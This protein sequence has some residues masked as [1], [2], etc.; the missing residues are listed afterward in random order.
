MGYQLWTSPITGYRR[1]GTRLSELRSLTEAGITA[2]TIV[3][4]LKSCPADA[5]ASKA[6]Q[7]LRRR[8]FD[9]AG[10]K[11]N[12]ES[13]VVTWVRT[14]ELKDGLV[15]DHERVLIAD[16]LISD[17]T[18]LSEVMKN[19]KTRDF[20]F[21]LIGSEVRGIVAR[22]DL[23]K[24]P[25]RIYLFTLI[26]LLEMHLS[27]WISQEYPDESWHKE[28]GEE[29]VSKAK[30]IQKERQ[31]QKLEQ[32]LLECI[33]FCDKRDLITS[34]EKLR[35]KLNMGS[36]G[37]AN[38]SLRRAELLRNELAH[39]QQDLTH[40]SSWESLISLI[41]WIETV[42]DRSDAE[43]EEGAAKHAEDYADGLWTSA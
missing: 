22:A 7:M 41:E 36:K 40:G 19:L 29:R 4:P 39:S 21:V 27:F 18:P 25:V 14:N 17:A 11:E 10:I 16:D 23:N 3:E 13:Q 42:V 12:P 37:A 43:V 26:S 2:H 5:P 31:S 1:K 6:A 9:V 24:P 32:T 34:R 28:L 38:R 30:G 15:R 35:T 8:G 33:Q 20:T